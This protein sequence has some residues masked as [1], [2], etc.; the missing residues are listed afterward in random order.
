M[1]AFWTPQ[2]GPQA[3]AAICP[4]DFTFFGGSRGGGKSDCLL[5]RQ[6]RGA[7]KHAGRWNGIII[8]RKYKE[9]AELRR[10]IDGMITEGLPAARVGGAQQTNYIRFRNG[11][12]VIMP[13]IQSLQMVGDHVGQQYT[14]IGIDECTTFPFFHQMVEKLKGSLRS[15][16]GVPCRMFGTGNPGG[17]GHNQVKQYFRLGVAQGVKP[18][19]VITD[20]TGQTRIYIP[21]FLDD[22]RILCEN[23]PV[24]VRRLKS[25]SDPALRAAWLKGDWD[26]YIGQ[27]FLLTEA[28]IVTPVPIPPS[29]WI[30]MTFDWGYGKPFSVGWWWVDSEGRGYRFLEW[31]GCSDEPDTGLRLTDRQIAEGIVQRE[32][33]AGIWKRPNVVRKAGPDCW[34]K[35]PDYKGG[36]QG[37]STAEAFAAK[38]IYLTPGDP[39]RRQK[40]N[41]FRARLEVPRD[42]SGVQIDRPMIQIYTPAALHFDCPVA[43]HVR[44]QS[45]GHRYRPGGPRLRRGLPFLHGQAHQAQGDQARA[46]RVR[47]PH[48]PDRAAA[49]R[50]HRAAG[51]YEP[52]ERGGACPGRVQRCRWKIA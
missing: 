46:A 48:R 17:P 12:Q 39:N 37:P 6:L 18:E 51:G 49:G 16:H 26:V 28:H 36:G 42:E 38:E 25:I 14:E 43:V 30:Y 1:T 32:K 9:F 22:N 34:N 11:A 7:E 4:A 35:K 29:A 24:Y 2:P 20:A 19:T 52:V 13:A 5:G 15:L 10:R 31:Y 44:G 40:I 23:D 47:P 41:Q 45:R 27:A 3:R 8:R 21:S 50:R 33:D